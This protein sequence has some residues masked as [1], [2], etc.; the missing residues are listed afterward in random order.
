MKNKI[1]LIFTFLAG[2]QISLAQQT[3]LF[4]F[5]DV[6]PEFTYCFDSFPEADR[7]CTAAIVDNPTG[8]SDQINT[9][10]KVFQ[11]DYS[12]GGTSDFDGSGMKMNGF[13]STL[14]SNGIY[15]SMLFRS[16]TNTS[17]NVPVQLQLQ[18]DGNNNVGAFTNY[19]KT[20][21][22]W[23]ELFFEFDLSGTDVFIT[24][25]VDGDDVFSIV[26]VFPNNGVSPTDDTY[27]IDNIIQATT[28]LSTNE[29]TKTG[30]SWYVSGSDLVVNGNF[31]G[32]FLEIFD[33]SGRL[34][35]THAIKGNQNRIDISNLN[36]GVYILTSDNGSTKF[37]Y[38]R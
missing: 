28:A 33:I 27:E 18:I 1:T 36:S 31:S 5:D 19:T 24:G 4:N 23:E 32:K 17:G 20:D 15:F 12:G 22:S 13:T 10:A 14:N 6:T 29:F 26:Q 30:T 8:S 7:E 11:L 38:T 25:N 16:A 3:I 35:N 37:V 21:G 9:S 34:L 2:I